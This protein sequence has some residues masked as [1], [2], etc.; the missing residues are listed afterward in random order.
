MEPTPAPGASTLEDRA[1][2]VVQTAHEGRVLDIGDARRIEIALNLLVVAAAFVAQLIAHERGV[3][4]DFAAMVV[5]AIEGAQR[6]ELRTLAAFVA[7][8]VRMVEDEL[9][10]LITGC[11]GRHADRHRVDEQAQLGKV[12][13]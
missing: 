6:V 13:A 4:H 2:V 12:E 3:F 11:A 7:H 1:R 8:I 9:T 5:L 10:H